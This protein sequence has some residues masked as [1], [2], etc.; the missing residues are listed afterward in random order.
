MNPLSELRAYLSEHAAICRARRW[1]GSLFHVGVCQQIVEDVA[2][3]EL[4]AA[5]KA[6]RAELLDIEA[7]RAIQAGDLKRA[8]ALLRTAERDAHDATEILA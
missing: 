8:V 7:D 1:F 3:N 4:R 6:H 5:S 2:A